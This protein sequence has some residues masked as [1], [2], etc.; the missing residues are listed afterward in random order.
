MDDM[1]FERS[2]FSEALDDSEVI[3]RSS[4]NTLRSGS[5]LDSPKRHSN[6]IMRAVNSEKLATEVNSEEKKSLFEKA[7]KN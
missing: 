2:G 5:I 1:P 4:A 3:L 6:L 7:D